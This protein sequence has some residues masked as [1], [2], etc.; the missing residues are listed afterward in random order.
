MIQIYNL[1]NTNFEKNGDM[2]LFPQS[3]TVDAV[4]NGAW[5]AEIKHPIDKEG[6]W[7]Y[8]K[9]EAVVKMESFNGEQLFRI[10][11]KEKSDSGV[12]A[13]LRPIFLM[14]K[15]IVSCWM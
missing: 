10:K 12:V 3:A 4:L 9:E 2:T 8:I 13:T 6:R 1:E 7:K 15:K 5:E 14:Q 11:K